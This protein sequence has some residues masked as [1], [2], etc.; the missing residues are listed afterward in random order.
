M[1]RAALSLVVVAVVAA[2]VAPRA[3]AEDAADDEALIRQGV[4]LRRARKD[5]EALA[6]FQA[7]FR[8]RPTPRAQAQ[9]GFA[10][11]SLGRWVEAA[12]DLEAALQAAQDPW[13]AKNAGSAR[14]ALAAVGQHLGQLQVLGSPAGAKVKVDEQDIGEIPM[15]AAA[16]VPAGEVVITVSAPG[17]MSIN[18]KVTIA[19]GAIER[20]T[21][22]LHAV[23]GEPAG[24][25]T[26]PAPPPAVAQPPIPAPAPPPATTTESSMR[27]LRLAAWIATGAA[28]IALAV[29]IAE[30]ASYLGKKD[31]F[32]K[33]VAAGP[34][35]SALDNRGAT[36]CSSLY[37][38]MTGAK[39]AA[40][41][42][43]IGAGVLAAGAAALFFV[44]SGTGAER[45]I[46]CAPRAS[47]VAC[48]L[49]F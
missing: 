15:S 45:R 8:A 7:A 24:S 44:S 16:R 11:Q 3:R 4:E 31:D 22:V 49:A 30:N 26:T 39:T 46:A 35:G 14:D 23:G 38:G 34:C 21:I 2:A 48:A 6:K 36:G 5:D 43:F 18:R 37:D 9:M 13:I 27:P 40:V 47:G 25:A 28:A 19:P 33:G 32:D 12:R 42:G 17:H 1:S 29:G 41:A 10:E 20:E